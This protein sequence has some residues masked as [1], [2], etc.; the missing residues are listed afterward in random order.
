M[1]ISSNQRLADGSNKGRKWGAC[2]ES[3]TVM[4][5]LRLTFIILLNLIIYM[6]Y[7]D[8]TLVS[9]YIVVVD[10]AILI[11]TLFAFFIDSEL[12]NCV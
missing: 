4:L 6:W 5:T 9:C 11:H 2:T 1:R 12:F 3:E 8:D 7:H 10:N